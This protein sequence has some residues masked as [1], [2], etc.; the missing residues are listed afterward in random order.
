AVFDVDGARGVVGPFL[1]GHVEAADVV[2]GDAEVEEP[3]P[4]VLNPMLVMVIG[5]VRADEVLDLHLLELTGAE[6]EVA[7]GDL[8][9]EGLADLADAERRLLPGRGEHVVEVDEDALCRLRAQVVQPGLRV[10]G[11]EEGLDQAGELLGL[12]PLA[13]GAAVRAD[14]IGHAVVRG[15]L[16]LGLIGLEQVVLAVA[17]VAVEAFDERVDEGLDVAGGLPDALGQDDRGV[18]ADDVLTTAH[19]GLPPLGLDVVLELDA[20]WPVVPCRA[21]TAIDLFGLEDESSALGQ[22]DDGIQLRLCHYVLSLIQFAHGRLPWL[23]GTSLT[24]R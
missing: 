12:G 2:D 3:V 22:G 13:A 15:L 16:V 9:A 1:G 4:A 11:A 10:D 21:G 5:Y 17:F 8:V 14:D 20:Q 18:E 19:E 7:R 24:G 6:D 23:P